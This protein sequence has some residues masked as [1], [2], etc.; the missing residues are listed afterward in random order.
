M[1]NLAEKNTEQ[2]EF[3]KGDFGIDY[4]NRNKTI[5]TVNE[6]YEKQTGTTVENI[7]KKFFDQIDRNSTI[8]ELG[9]N[10]G[11]NLSVLSKMG[12]KNL[13]GIEINETAYSI[14]KE[15]N[16]NVNFI[17][18]SIEDFNSTN[19]YDLVYTAGVLIHIHPDTL[20]LIIKKMD[21]LSKK[22]IFGFEYFSEN[23]VEIKYRNN[24]KTCWK[25]NFPELIKQSN[26]S[27]KTIKEEKF[28][29]KDENICDIAYLLE[30]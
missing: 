15:N 2:R 29:Y 22:F 18:S 21:N 12:F 3:W 11:L 8:I 28:Q 6:L 20:P 24:L 1:D 19:T 26:P 7:F 16:P 5:E 10:V 27:F 9:C 30:K 4:I 14:A 17:N 23:L 13:T 25:Q